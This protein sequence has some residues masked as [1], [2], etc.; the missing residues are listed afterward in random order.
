MTAVRL[1]RRRYLA[2]PHCHGGSTFDI[3]STRIGLPGAED[4]EPRGPAR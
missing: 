2:R 3:V 4:A 1:G